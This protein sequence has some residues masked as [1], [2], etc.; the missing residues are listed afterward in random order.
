MKVSVR[1]SISCAHQFPG[2]PL[3]GHTYR[4]TATV[5]GPVQDTGYVC[6]FESLR[7]GIATI[8]SAL[9]HKK[10][11]MLVTS[12][13]TAERVA[14]TIARAASKAMDRIVNVRVEVGDEGYVE[15]NLIE[16]DGDYFDGGN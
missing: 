15:T 3:H 9:D 14:L 12:P 4:I 13:T 10:L 16:R 6:T 8:C 1:R 11:E 7:E 5:A 2:E